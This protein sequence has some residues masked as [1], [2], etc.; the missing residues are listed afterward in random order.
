MAADLAVFNLNKLEYAG[1]LSDPL[2]A[3]IFAGSS[4]QTEYTIVNGEIAVDRGMLCGF[5]EE[6]ITEK[7]NEISFKI[8]AGI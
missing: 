4:H 5:D 6:E 7:A 8:T 3:L 1:S 2:A